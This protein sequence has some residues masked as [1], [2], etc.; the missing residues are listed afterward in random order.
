MKLLSL[1]CLLACIQTAS[2]QSQEQASGKLQLIESETVIEIRQADKPI[3]TYNKVSPPLPESIAPI[4]QRS[5]FIHPVASPSGRV[6]TGAFAADHPHQNGIFTAWVMTQWN[7]RPIDF[8]NLGK[9]I[10]RVSHHSVI[11]Q[12]AEPGKIGFV[13]DLV[14]TAEEKPVVE[15]LRE[16]W[17]VTA[18]ATDGSYHQFDLETTQTA[19]TELPLMIEKYHYGGVG[20]RGPA[21]WLSDKESSPTSQAADIANPERFQFINDRGS[22]RIQGNEQPA[23]WVTATGQIDGRAVSIT[24]LCHASNFRSP[25]AARIHPTK[26]YFA[27]SPCIDGSFTIDRQNDYQATFRYLVTDSAPD[28]DWI[29]QQWDQ[30]HGK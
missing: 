10:G 8:W 20:Y 1:I 25:Q 6:V 12:F 15:I 7:D 19:M 22:D 11:Q 18:W 4:Y 17:K 27:F 13:V 30:W 3:L 14:H 26:P 5:G 28:A 2:A 29:N 23:R 16:R 9:G 24:V 21:S